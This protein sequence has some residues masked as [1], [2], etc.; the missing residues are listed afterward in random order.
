VTTPDSSLPALLGFTAEQIAGNADRLGLEWKLRPATVYSGTTETSISATATLDGDSIVQPVTSV[1]GQLFP[2]QRVMTMSVPPQG[3]Y[4]VGPYGVRNGF[5]GVKLTKTNQSIASG[6]LDNVSWASS[7]WDTGN[8]WSSGATVTYPLTGIYVL[9]LWVQWEDN[10]TGIRYCD[11]Q[12][13][14][15]T[16]VSRRQNAANNSEQGFAQ[17]VSA[18]AGN[19][20]TF[21]F[22]QNSGGTRTASLLTGTVRYVGSVS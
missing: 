6:S 8:F 12:M 4:V 16:K 2:G 7:E 9:T 10:S 14:G 1:I 17:E 21:R 3:I 18:T 13:S 11:A 15:V 20:M 22:F 5:T 19:T